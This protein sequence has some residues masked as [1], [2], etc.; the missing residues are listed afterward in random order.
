MVA[1]LVSESV[2]VPTWKM[3]FDNTAMLGFFGFVHILSH[4]LIDVSVLIKIIYDVR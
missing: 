2:A 1:K 4:I 3:H